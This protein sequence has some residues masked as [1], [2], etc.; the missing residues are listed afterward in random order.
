MKG[1][2]EREREKLVDNLM[3]QK[4]SEEEE[5]RERLEQREMRVLISNKFVF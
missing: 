1:G 2:T 4:C 5:I 3:Y